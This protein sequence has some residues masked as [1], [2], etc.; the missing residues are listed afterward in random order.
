M[1]IKFITCVITILFFSLQK[2]YGQEDLEK[3][4]KKGLKA[5]TIIEAGQYWRFG[6]IYQSCPY[7]I[8]PNI[9]NITGI[10]SSFSLS[11][12]QIIYWGLAVG[13]E[14]ATGVYIFPVYPEI[15]ISPFRKNEFKPVIYISGGHT[16][17]W[18]GYNSPDMRGFLFAAG[19]GIKGKLNKKLSFALNIGY[20]LQGI[21]YNI[22]YSEQSANYMACSGGQLRYNYVFIKTGIVFDHYIKPISVSIEE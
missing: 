6:N 10:Y 11:K 2:S 12:R 14:Y 4:E 22:S 7:T 19:A 1:R 18:G 5:Q 21:T 20:R 3:K 16:E 15:R 13:I 8:P 17:V 9:N